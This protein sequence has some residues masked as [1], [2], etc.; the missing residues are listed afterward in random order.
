[1]NFVTVLFYILAI[2]LV[3]AAARVVTARSPVTAVLHLI[4]TFFTASMLW[5]LLGAEFL[6]LLLVI[7]YVGAVLVMFLFV[8]MML[9]IRWKIARRL[10]RP[11]CRWASAS[12]WSWC[13]KWP[14]CWVTWRPRPRPHARGLQQHPPLGEAMYTDYVF[15]VQGGVI[16]ARRHGV[17]HR[18]DPAQ[19]QTSS[20][21][22]PAA[23]PGTCRRSGAHGQYSGAQ[24]FRF[25]QPRAQGEAK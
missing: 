1:M 13:W 6:S 9:D 11:I 12:P 14:S 4:L 3:V 21:M 10:S 17:R 22:D 8:V 7:V 23:G 15:A 20:A 2:V 24:G 16:P 18:A 19:A 25:S 5:M